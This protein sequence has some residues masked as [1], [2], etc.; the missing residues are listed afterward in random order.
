MHTALLMPQ[1]RSLSAS[2]VALSEVTQ[3]CPDRW[4]TGFTPF[5]PSAVSHPVLLPLPRPPTPSASRELCPCRVLILRFCMKWAAKSWAGSSTAGEEEGEGLSAQNCPSSSRFCT[6]SCPCRDSEDAL[7]SLDHCT[8]HALLPAHQHL[9]RCTFTSDV[10]EKERENQAEYLIHEESLSSSFALTDPKLSQW[11]TVHMDMEAAGV[12]Q[13]AGPAPQGQHKE[14]Q[15]PTPAV[16]G[17]PS[18]VLLK[19]AEACKPGSQKLHQKNLVARNFSNQ[20]I[21]LSLITHM[22]VLWFNLS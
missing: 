14:H 15:W 10:T 16:Q 7:P 13:G 2:P 22:G 1:Q 3:R 17:P 18:T 21:C 6:G 20:V 4:K 12:G 9:P 19:E 11:S 8:S 5:P